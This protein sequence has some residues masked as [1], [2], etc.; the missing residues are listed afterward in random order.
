MSETGGGDVVGTGD[1]QEQEKVC[2][3]QLWIIKVIIMWKFWFYQHIIGTITNLV[4]C[5]FELKC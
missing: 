4:V 5:E 1:G 3:E 2:S